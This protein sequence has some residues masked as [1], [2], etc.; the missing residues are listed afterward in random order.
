MEKIKLGVSACLL[1]E[2][3]RYNG[4]HKRELFLTDTLG[5]FVEL[6]GVCPEAECGL[7]VPR[8]A[9]RLEGDPEG[10]RLMTVRSRKDL[11]A[12]LAFWAQK[13]VRELEAENLWG[14]IFKSNSPSCGAAR[15]KVYGEKGGPVKK[16][17]GLFARAFMAHFPL[18]PMEDEIRLHDPDRRENFIDQVFTLKR[19][20]EMVAQKPGLGNLMTFHTRHKY[21]IMAH[22]PRRHQLLGRLA[23]QG[24]EIP[25][26]ELYARYLGLLLEALGLKATVKKHANVLLHLLGYF[27]KA[28]S[29]EEKEELLEI[30]E[31]YRQGRVPLI[32]PVTLCNHYARK[33]RQPDL[34]EQYYLNPHPVELHLRNH[35]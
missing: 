2:K 30:I 35:V 19:W 16:G 21:L 4:G 29:P 8:E 23:A 28:L 6:V 3:V 9:M 20:R 15:V 18:T 33:Y 17:M 7:G 24:N 13:R 26:K 25:L 32:A 31:N 12:R 34:M 27:K 22:S 1:G 14:F 5:R 10:P 11:T